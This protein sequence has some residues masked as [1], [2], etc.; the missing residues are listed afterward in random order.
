MMAG[1]PGRPASCS[2]PAAGGGRGRSGSAP[3]RTLV[4]TPEAIRGIPDLA[5]E[6]RPV[7]EVAGGGLVGG[8]ERL[9]VEFRQGDVGGSSER[10]EGGDE[11]Q[12]A[13]ACAR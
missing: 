10:G 5:G 11:A 4:R 3:V 6:P 9:E 2:K 8:Q 7:E 12:F 1:L 13:A